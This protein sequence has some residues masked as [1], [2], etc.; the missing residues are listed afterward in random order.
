MY[1][2]NG[3]FYNKSN[4]IENFVDDNTETPLPTNMKIVINNHKFYLDSY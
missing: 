1:S 3:N 4:I 2:A